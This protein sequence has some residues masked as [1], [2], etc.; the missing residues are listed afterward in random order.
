[1]TASEANR[2]RVLTLLHAETE[3]VFAQFS[4]I[5]KKSPAVQQGEPSTLTVEPSPIES[6][7]AASLSHI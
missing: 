2:R 4:T 5:D 3:A 1:M 6:F 7:Q